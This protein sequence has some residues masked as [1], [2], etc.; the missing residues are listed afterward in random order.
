MNKLDSTIYLN[1]TSKYEN[2]PANINKP[3]SVPSL[4]VGLKPYLQ[5]LRTDSSRRRSV[6]LSI[7]SGSVLFLLAMYLIFH[8][9]KYILILSF[10][11]F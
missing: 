3:I 11:P 2:P 8:P 9:Y 5:I 10:F 7:L 4:N 1:I 6:P